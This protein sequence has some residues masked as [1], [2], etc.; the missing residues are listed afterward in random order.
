MGTFLVE[1]VERG[2]VEVPLMLMRQED[3][4]DDRKRVEIE[5]PR[6][7]DAQL[8]AVGETESVMKEWVYQDP[9]AIRRIDPP[10]MPEECGA[11]HRSPV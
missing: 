4:V 2:D 7:I 1:E 8:D 11:E 5:C 10:M 3:C 9:R 6:R